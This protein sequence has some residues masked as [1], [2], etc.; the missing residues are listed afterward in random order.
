MIALMK[1]Q[2]QVEEIRALETQMSITLCAMDFSYFSMKWKSNCLETIYSSDC[3][4]RY[5]TKTILKGRIS[6]S[7]FFQLVIVRYAKDVRCVEKHS[8]Q[9]RDYRG[10]SSQLQWPPQVRWG[11]SVTTLLCLSLIRW[12]PLT[13]IRHLGLLTWVVHKHYL[14]TKTPGT[15]H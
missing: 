3:S 15:R 6:S 4:G 9:V 2:G 11:D 7:N 13:T 14:L 8:M 12:V 5:K 10:T 1:K